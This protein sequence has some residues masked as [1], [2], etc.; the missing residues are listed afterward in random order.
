MLYTVMILAA[1]VIVCRYCYIEGVKKTFEI[2]MKIAQE[3][4]LDKDFN[5]WNDESNQVS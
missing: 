1:V 4:L 2:F 3:E 5:E